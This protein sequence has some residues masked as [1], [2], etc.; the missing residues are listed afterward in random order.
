V[1]TNAFEGTKSLKN[2]SLAKNKLTSIP[3][4]AISITSIEVLDISWNELGYVNLKNVVSLKALDLSHTNQTGI[5]P[6]SFFSAGQLLNV[7]LTD[8]QINSIDIK[9]FQYLPRLQHLELSNNHITH[10]P[11]NSFSTLTNLKQLTLAQNNLKHL[12]KGAFKGLMNITML[13]LSLNPWDCHCELT[14]LFDWIY[15][16]QKQITNAHNLKNIKC[17]T[18]PGHAGQ[19]FSHLRENPAAMDC[20]VVVTPPQE[21]SYYNRFGDRFS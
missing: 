4:K 19:T 11:A 3:A 20:L 1:D 9:S 13:D 15:T 14:W 17:A 16:M 5:D 8:N 12:E 21:R 7:S 2:L 10:I 6:D 18:P